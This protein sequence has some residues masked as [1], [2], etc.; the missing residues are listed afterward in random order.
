[1]YKILFCLIVGFLFSDQRH[2]INTYEKIMLE[3]GET[4]LEFYYINEFPTLS[5]SD[6]ENLNILKF[7]VEVEI[8]MS[9]CLEVAFY[10]T[11]KEYPVFED[12]IFKSRKFSY[13]EYK[14]RLKYKIF[15]SSN[16]WT[17]FFY[18]ELKGKP[19]FSAWTIEQKLIFTKYFGNLNFSFNPILEFE[20]E[21]VGGKWER[22]L[23]TEIA[24]GISIEKEYFSYGIDLKSSEYA[25]Y[26]GPVFGHGNEDKWWSFGVMRKLAGKDTKNELIIKSI[27]GFHF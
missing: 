3:P 6:N 15:D 20:N 9:E 8:G 10:N 14:L 22:E 11:F 26:I 18:S 1:M 4:E 16:P 17:P 7:Q 13:D 25:T 2:F 23:E 12:D 24:A 5:I 19:D 21:K 27:M